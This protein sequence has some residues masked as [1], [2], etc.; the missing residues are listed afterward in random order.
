MKTHEHE[1]KPQPVE[2]VMLS[3]TICCL[4]MQMKLDVKLEIL[5]TD[6]PNGGSNHLSQINILCWY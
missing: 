6:L 3:M 1:G 4:E 2:A 5:A